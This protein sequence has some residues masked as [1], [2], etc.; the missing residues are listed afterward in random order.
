[1]GFWHGLKNWLVGGDATKGLET[2]G[3]NADYVDGFLKNQLGGVNQRLAPQVQAQQV[4]GSQQGQIRD[5]Q[6][7][8][9]QYLQGIM[10]GNHAGAG[11]MAVNRQV[12]QASAAQQAAARMARGANAALAARTAARNT[13]DIG[14]AGAG[15]AAQAQMAD[16]QQ[17]AGQL[18]QALS[19]IRGQDLSFAGQNAQ[20][21]QQAGQQ[22]QD[23]MLRQMMMNDQA[24]SGYLGQLM[25]LDAQQF[26]A[27][28]A[29]RNMAAQDQGHL[30]T[31]LQIGG[32]LAGAA[33][34]GPAGAAIGGKIG[35]AAGGGGYTAAQADQL[36]RNAGPGN[37]LIRPGG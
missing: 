15:Q 17:A 22:N 20:F 10:Q 34:G 36:A 30:G 24:S 4:D 7:G 14:V 37:G 21:R 12:G 16:Q 9:A 13:A 8:Q 3:Q 31:L 26:Q 32:T 29:K 35:G 23:A 18:G 19:G 28:M 25:G 27:E 2:R 6:L 5:Q 33:V 11:E 1:M